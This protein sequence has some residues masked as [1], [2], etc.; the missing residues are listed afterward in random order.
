MSLLVI[1]GTI[2]VVTM[3]VQD[4]K[5]DTVSSSS[6][7]STGPDSD[8]LASDLE[9]HF[10]YLF[11]ELSPEVPSLLDP[12]TAAYVAL[13][14]MAFTDGPWW[15]T[16]TSDNDMLLRQRFPLVVLY[17]ATGGISFWD[18]DWLLAGTTECDFE[19]ITCDMY[20]TIFALELHQRALVGELPNEISWLTN[21]KILN[22]R[23]NRLQGS[24]PSG[25]FTELTSLEVLDLSFNEFSFALPEEFLSGL[26]QLETFS[27]SVNSLTG[28]LPS[29]GRLP[30][31]LE[32]FTM[33]VNYLS[34]SLPETWLEHPMI[35]LQVVDLGDNLIDGTISSNISNWSQLK[36]LGLYMTDISGSLP[37]ELGHLPLEE[38]SLA[39]SQLEGSLP[40]EI[41]ELSKLELFVAGHTFLT[42][43]LETN[44]GNLR[45]LQVFNLVHCPISG[46]IPTEIGLLRRLEWL[47]LA[48]TDIEGTIPN[49]L[50]ELSSLSK[51]QNQ[52]IAHSLFR[53]RI[54]HP[55][56]THP[57]THAHSHASPRV[58]PTL[59]LLGKIWLHGT[60]LE[61]TF[62]EEV[63]SFRPAVNDLRTDCLRKIECTCC[64]NCF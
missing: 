28:P 58:S 34:G 13:E 43:S 20:G 56:S 54:L 15:M 61:G 12:T 51:Y 23:Q 22:L 16:D 24:I 2:A 60:D 26:T 44:I 6:P 31:S 55:D 36:S 45:N 32:Y 63:C 25:I 59:F 47:Q 57:P 1:A 3:V 35:A 19:S 8:F 10:D 48:N 21:L 37:S 42:G 41:Y 27:A 53:P 29:G 52:C 9:A 50:S 18:T 40:T 5:E 38:L 62:P 64:T 33:S 39:T 11:K 17:F 14:W 4:A 30:S 7:Q 46:T 49:E